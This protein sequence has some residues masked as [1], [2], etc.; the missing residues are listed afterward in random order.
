MEPEVYGWMAP[1]ALVG[2]AGG[3]ALFWAVAV[4][5]GAGGVAAGAVARRCALAASGRWRST[6]AS[7]VLTGFPWALPAYAWVETP[8]IQAAALVGPHG[9]GFLTLLAGLLPGLATLARGRRSAA[10]LVAAGWGFGGLAAGAAGAGAGGA[11]GGAAGAAE[12]AAG[13]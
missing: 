12:R 8:V 3:L 4:R 6:R 7:H 1:F 9:L 2:M 10:A 11:A 13:R 5:A